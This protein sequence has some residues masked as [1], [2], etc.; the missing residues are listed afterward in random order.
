MQLYKVSFLFR[1]TREKAQLLGNP[2]RK[3]GRHFRDVLEPSEKLL[4]ILKLLKLIRIEMI[5]NGKYLI[6]VKVNKCQI[7]KEVVF[8]SQKS[9]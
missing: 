8:T 9:A 4:E 5:K 3:I 2:R 6:C 1:S 7:P